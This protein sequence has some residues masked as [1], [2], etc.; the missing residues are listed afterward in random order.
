MSASCHLIRMLYGPNKQQIH[1]FL[2]RPLDKEKASLLETKLCQITNGPG[3]PNIE[4]AENQKRIMAY[5]SLP[6]FI[7]KLSFY[8]VKG[9]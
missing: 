4:Q 2:N 5:I 1:V 9:K 7:R 8:C 3:T 6:S